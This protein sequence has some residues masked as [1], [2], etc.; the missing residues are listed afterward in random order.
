MEL[1]RAK[2]GEYQYYATLQLSLLDGN[3]NALFSSLHFEGWGSVKWYGGGTELQEI[4]CK[5]MKRFKEDRDDAVI[6][7]YPKRLVHTRI[8]PE[9]ALLRTF[10]QPDSDF[11]RSDEECQ[12]DFVLEVLLTVCEE[13]GFKPEEIREENIPPLKI[14]LERGCVYFTRYRNH[15]NKTL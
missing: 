11:R 10:V 6:G 9:Y 3:A 5:E 8:T 1:E 14:D 13:A 7:L 4:M 12:R 2:K 15:L